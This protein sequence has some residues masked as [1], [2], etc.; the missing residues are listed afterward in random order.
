MAGNDLVNVT[1]WT[2]PDGDVGLPLQGGSHPLFQVW[3]DDGA[4]EDEDED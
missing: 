2:T 3:L 4:S 1:N